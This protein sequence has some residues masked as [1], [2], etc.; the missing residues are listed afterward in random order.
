MMAGESGTALPQT[1]F[2]SRLRL[3]ACGVYARWNRLEATMSAVPIRFTRTVRATA[4]MIAAVLFPSAHAQAASLDVSLTSIASLE[5][6]IELAGPKFLS[7]PVGLSRYAR[8]KRMHVQL[9]RMRR[10]KAERRARIRQARS[11]LARFEQHGQEFC[12][13]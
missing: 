3:R 11:Q 12:L 8:I 9:A 5:P 6:Q 10:A 13:A 7:A 4:I 1:R 2:R